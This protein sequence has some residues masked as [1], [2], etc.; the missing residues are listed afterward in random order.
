MRNDADNR[1]PCRGR[2]V[3]FST[4]AAIAIGGALVAGGVTNPGQAAWA[5]S[6]AATMNA[7]ATF[8]DLVERVKPAV[9][10]IST[11]QKVAQR[12]PMMPFQLPPGSPY[13]EL[14]RKFFEEQQGEGNMP[15][16]GD[17][18][19]LGSGFIVDPAGYVVTNHHVVGEADEITVVL[20]DGTRLP[21]T[22]KG[23]DPKTDLALLK[24][25]TATPLPFVKFGDSSKTRVGDWVLAVGNPFGLGGSVTA[26]II[27]ANGRDIQSGPYDDYL[28][29]D[30]SINRGNSGGPTFNLAGEVIG[31]NTAIFSP[32]GGSVGIG[33]AIPSSLAR[34][35][36][37]QLR[38]SGSVQRGWLGVSIQGMT[39]ELAAGLGLGKAEGAL[40]SEVFPE[41]PAANAGVRQ[42]DVIVAYNGEAIKEARELPRLV[43]VT[44][45]GQS[46]KLTVLRGGREVPLDLTIAKMPDEQPKLAADQPS[47]QPAP[48]ADKLGL[49]LAQLTPD[50][51]TKLGL[52]GDVRGVVV[53]N[54]QQ[55]SEAAR[56]GLRPG[57]VIVAVNQDPVTSPA[58]V[59]DRV[60]KAKS[61]DRKSVV[62]LVNRNGDQRFLALDVPA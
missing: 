22:I 20:N 57:D 44:K 49:A 18:H 3:L 54:V 28:Q 59:A 26:G 7:P 51:R 33:F 25:E 46:A 42:G 6:T 34:D 39:P 41:T 13:E 11:T 10:N 40:V 61:G 36:I 27:S 58:E 5:A 60:A 24:V 43:A 15:P 45:A 21:A 30:A 38:D 62:L 9:V 1:R 17:A 12:P 37:A 8:A 55:G 47:A 32:N 16:P 50:R 4:V 56:K 35:V 19:A 14:F 52:D 2:R 23:R 31:I 29:I 53:E 48:V